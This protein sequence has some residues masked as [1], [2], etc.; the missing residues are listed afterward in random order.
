MVGAW[1]CGFRL[2]LF[3]PC[4]STG[5]QLVNSLPLTPLI[6]HAFPAP[7]EWDQLQRRCGF[8]PGVALAFMTKQQ[9]EQYIAQRLAA[10]RLPSRVPILVV[11]TGLAGAEEAAQCLQRTMPSPHR[12]SPQEG[13]EQQKEQKTSKKKPQQQQEHQQPAPQEPTPIPPWAQGFICLLPSEPGVFSCTAMRLQ[14]L[15]GFRAGAVM[16][17]HV[18]NVA[19]FDG[20]RTIADPRALLLFSTGAA[21]EP[22]GV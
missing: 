16:P 22:T 1:W 9:P 3:G 11:R 8:L 14:D 20:P 2:G 13:G 5:E 7:S 6:P 10:L 12:T 19:L 4:S 17:Y 15:D 21:L 18:V